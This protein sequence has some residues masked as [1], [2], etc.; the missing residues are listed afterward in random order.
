MLKGGSKLSCS[1]GLKCWHAAGAAE[2]SVS[3]GTCDLCKAM[4]LGKSESLSGLRYPDLY[5]QATQIFTSRL[6]GFIYLG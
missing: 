1:S 6:P 2:S 3:G 5:I 4:I